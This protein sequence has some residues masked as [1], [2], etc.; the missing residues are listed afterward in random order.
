MADL[1]QNTIPKWGARLSQLRGNNNGY[2]T[3]GF[4]PD[5]TCIKR[6]TTDPYNRS[7]P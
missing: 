5:F 1:D 3:L 7:L 4:E 6:F 2:P